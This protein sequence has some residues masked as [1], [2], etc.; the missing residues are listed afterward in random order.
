MDVEGVMTTHDLSNPT[1]KSVY[2]YKIV[3]FWLY[4]RKVELNYVVQWTFSVHWS[5]NIWLIKW[6]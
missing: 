1:L 2:F 4:F 3:Y 5:A 6:Y